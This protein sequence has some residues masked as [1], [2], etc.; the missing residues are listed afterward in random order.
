MISIISESMGRGLIMAN[1]I[2]FITGSQH[3]YGEETLIQVAKNSKEMVDF[4]NDKLSCEI[5]WTDTVKTADEITKTMRDANNDSDCIGVIV[6]MHTFS[7]SQ[8]WI[9]G[10][11]II[12]KP[13]C[14]L[15]T[16]Y[17]EALPYK[18]IDMDFMN[19]NQSAHGDREHGYIY[20]RM[21]KERKV[22][23]GYWRSEDTLSE[24]EVFSKAAIGLKT[25]KALKICRFGDNMRD[26]AVTEGDKVQARLKLGFS[27]SGYGIGDLVSCIDKVTDEEVFELYNSYKKRYNILTDDIDSVK[28]QA[29][30]EIGMERFLENGGFGGFTTT[31]EDL[32]GLSQLPGL[33]VQR[34]MEKGYGFGAEGDW[35]TAALLRILKE[36]SNN[37]STSFMEDYTYHLEKG[38]E[39]VLGAHMLEVCPT[40]ADGEMKIDVKPL[41]I[42]GK[43]PPARIIFNSKKG[44]AISV[45]L[46]DLGDRFRII[47]ADIMGVTAPEEMPNLP[48]AGCMWKLY[49]NFSDGAK[50]WILAG[51]AHHSVVSFALTKEHIIDLAA[52]LNIECVVIDKNLDIS[53]LITDMKLS[54]IIYK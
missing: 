11:S 25:A 24:L 32:H 52:M 37:N 20:A 48:V 38:N 19:L 31:F 6:W 21:R 4:F 7:P 29:K 35:K 12:N 54:D 42:G 53:R 9:E 26:V 13:V 36:M 23:V 40:I 44:D 1:K 28:E 49:P 47:V 5:V 41:G 10:L 17:N 39:M 3:L 34:L 33:A 18:T 51:G 43:N 15:H 45:S 2:Y 50:A 30:Y 16:Q 8:M 46:V 14:H 27:V 22:V